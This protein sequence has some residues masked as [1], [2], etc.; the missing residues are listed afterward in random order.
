MSIKK[1]TVSLMC[2]L[3]FVVFIGASVL[4]AGDKVPLLLFT[5]QS[6]FM[7]AL[8]EA[9]TQEAKKLGME[10]YILDGQWQSNV[11]ISQMEDVIAKGVAAI[12]ISPIDSVEII[13][14]IKKANMEGIPVFTTDA[15]ASGGEI[16]GH[17]GF[18]N[19][20][21]GRAAALWLGERLNGKGTVLELGGSLGQYHAEMR[22]KGF[23]DG[24][25]EYPGIKVIYK[26]CDWQADKAQAA[27]M[28]VFSAKPDVDAIFAASDNM[29]VGADPALRA[30]GKLKKVG[31]PGHVVVV[32]IDAAP[33]TVKRIK[34]GFQDASVEQD[35]YKMGTL[36]AQNIYRK[37]TG[38][39]YAK[40]I[41]LQ[42][43]VVT[44]E[45]AYD[46]KR[47]ANIFSSMHN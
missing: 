39:D 15:P 4:F 9:F 32:G 11:Q 17:V 1:C 13:P 23:Q 12:G 18:D 46:S 43:A 35:P 45:N 37:L 28:D 38:E 42:P 34:E 10:P 16:A 24:M 44:K 5:R 31:D 41:F 19:F 26:V 47:W 33:S 21:G 22:H 2:S 3:L 27:T 7:V 25:K 6:E 20:E 30:L 29:L 8:D 40:K 36:L 14:G